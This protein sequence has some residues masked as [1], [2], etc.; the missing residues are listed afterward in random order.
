MI[1]PE[2][3]ILDV[4]QLNPFSGRLRPPVADCKSALLDLARATAAVSTTITLTALAAATFPALFISSATTPAISASTS[5]TVAASAGFLF[6]SGHTGAEFGLGQIVLRGEAGEL[7]PLDEFA[8][9]L[10]DIDEQVQL[11][12]AD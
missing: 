8:D 7:A 1:A 6:R 12:R 3:P 10:F 9:E 2:F 5:A 11:F 4:F